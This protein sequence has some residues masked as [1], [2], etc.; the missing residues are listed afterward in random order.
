VLAIQVFVGVSLLDIVPPLSALNVSHSDVYC[1][2]AS[3]TTL[4]WI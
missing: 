2:L 3:G 1:D 4:D